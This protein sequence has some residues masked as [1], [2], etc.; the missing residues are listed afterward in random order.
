MSEKLDK[1]TVDAIGRCLRKYLDVENDAH[2]M[3]LLNDKAKAY[4]YINYDESVVK[5]YDDICSEIEKVKD[6]YHKANDLLDELVR[7]AREA[8]E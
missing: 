1:K 3:F 4:S 5:Q 7:F 2:Y 6:L 8:A